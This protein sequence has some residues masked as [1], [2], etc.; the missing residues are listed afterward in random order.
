MRQ[1]APGSARTLLLAA[2]ALAAAVMVGSI[3]FLAGKGGAPEGSANP[4]EHG[5]Q[6]PPGARDPRTRP[7]Q[8]DGADPDEADEPDPGDIVE[9]GRGGVVKSSREP[10][11]EDFTVTPDGL[12]AAFAAR[13]WEEIRRM[14]DDLQADGKPVPGDVLKQLMDMLA[15]DDTR[16]DAILA[17]GGV[18]D[19]ATG[20]AL[21][22]LALSGEA[23]IETRQAALDA[24]AKSGQAAAL[25]LLQQ[26]VGSASLDEQVARHAF[27]ALAGVGGPDATRT[28]LEL[29]GQHAGDDLSSALRTALGK[30]RDCDGG[31]AAALRA[32]RDKG[33]KE[34]LQSVLVAAQIQG[35]AAG[36]ELKSELQR[37]VESES[38]LLAF[39]DEIE[40]Q[41]MLGTAMPAAVAVG[42]VEPVLRAATT[43]GPLRDIALH[44]L[45]QARGD[46][47]AKQ[48]AAALSRSTDETERRELTVAL[49][50]TESFAA[51]ASLTGLL[52]DPSA[53]IRQAAARGLGMI[54]DPAAVKPILAHLPKAPPDYDFAR[55]LVD[56]LGT[57][58]ANESLVP[59]GKLA[60][61]EEDFWRQLRTY[62]QRSIVRIETGN[63]ESLRL[64]SKS[65][66]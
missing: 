53:N 24:I 6:V 60:V 62:V 41:L 45:R 39:T 66:R 48:I 58:G 29:L 14:I 40:R 42:I 37:L 9:F 26:L 17:L 50:E 11:G 34:V 44:A 59:L 5:G 22:E 13:H 35:K 31:L 47:A 55:N 19:D 7:K 23:S 36:P 54:R 2:L 49:S 28:L 30:T 15:K 3:A 43:S 27:F 51:T 64:D 10:S 21:A 20:R 33:D 25:P 16:I 63:P 12:R 56:A 65:G 8:V 38:S 4:E 32:A 52:D 46:A 18:K 1:F 57:I 61:S